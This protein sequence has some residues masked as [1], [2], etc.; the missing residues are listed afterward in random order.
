MKRLAFVLMAIVVLAGGCGHAVSERDKA[1]ALV[2]ESRLTVDK[3]LSMDQE[4]WRHFRAV[5]RDA[6]GVVIFPAVYKAA[7]LA[8]AEGG[9]GVLVG[10]DVSGNWSHPAFYVMGA[11]S[12][13]MQIGGQASEIVLALRTP[14]AVDAVIRHQGKLGADMGVTVGLI[15]A[16]LE[17]ST[18]ANLDA[19]IVAFAA[20]AGIFGGVSLEGAA[21]IRRQDLNEAYYGAG[22]EPGGIVLERAH[23]NPGADGLLRTLAGGSR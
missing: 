19:D 2:E 17:A 9:N 18:T 23:S 13:G 4:P 11:G 10:R 8:G 20:S 21:L 5:L 14:G 16:G 12:F 3:F 15:G 6:H 22:A 1:Q 7:F